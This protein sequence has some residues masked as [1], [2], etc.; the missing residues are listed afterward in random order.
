MD[1]IYIFYV[2]IFLLLRNYTLKRLLSVEHNPDI[3]NGDRYLVELELQYNAC[4]RNKT[5]TNNSDSS[6]NNNSLRNKMVRFSE[7]VY[8]PRGLSS[9][10][11]PTQ[12]TWNKQADVN[13][14]ITFAG[15]NCWIMHFIDTMSRI[16]ND[17]KDPHMNVII[18]DFSSPQ[19][20][21]IIM[22]YLHASSL[23]RYTLLKRSG[24]FHKTLAIQDAT[25]TISDPNAIA[26]QVDLHLTIPS[27][28]TDQVRKVCSHLD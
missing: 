2:F 1:L 14:I 6:N 13:Y 15:R 8:Q 26:V 9:I 4:N 18:V 21:G 5:D 16:Y 24:R 22:D 11:Y 19:N 7:Y 25:A 17:T 20:T 28:F 23:P 10:C 27:D 3:V 12:F